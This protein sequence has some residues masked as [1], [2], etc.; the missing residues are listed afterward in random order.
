MK[1]QK[2]RLRGGRTAVLIGLHCFPPMDARFMRVRR[3]GG[4]CDDMPKRFLCRFACWMGGINQ[5]YP[6]P[7]KNLLLIRAVD[8]AVPDAAAKKK[9]SV[10]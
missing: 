3:F 10:S 6:Y 2:N 9:T 5:D 8:L 7:R 4:K 1:A